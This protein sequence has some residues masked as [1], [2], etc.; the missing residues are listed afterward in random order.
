MLQSFEGHDPRVHPTA[1]VHDG[2]WVIGDVTLDAGVSIWPTAVLRGDMNPIHIGEDT[3]IQ[4]GAILHTTDNLSTTVVGKRVTVGHRAILHGCR[5][6]D[7][8]LIGM[9]AIV[10]DNAEIGPGCLIGAGALVTQRV[11]VPPGSLVLGSP[12]RVVRPVNDKERSWIDHSWSI[13]ARKR[14]RW[15]GRSV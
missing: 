2:A 4:D 3:N 14:D 12:A 5:I 10:L 7:G 1:W 13:Y 15:R 8:C 11:V 9:G 6:G